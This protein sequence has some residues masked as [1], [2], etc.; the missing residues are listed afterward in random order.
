MKLIKPVS[1]REFTYVIVVIVVALV[2]ALLAGC[3]GGPSAIESQPPASSTEAGRSD[4]QAQSE[5]HAAT[6][7]ASGEVPM[8]TGNEDTTLIQPEDT[9]VGAAAGQGNEDAAGIPS[10]G[11]VEFFAHDRPLTRVY[12]PTSKITIK[13]YTAPRNPYAA[14][15]VGQCHWYVFGRIQEEDTG[16]PQSFRDG[17]EILTK[18]FYGTGGIR[19][20]D[21]AKQAEL[22]G[23][24]T[25]KEAK[26]KSIAVWSSERLSHVAFVEEMRDGKP[27][28]S[29]S[30]YV[31]AD[32]S[33]DVG[34]DVEV[35]ILGDDRDI[36]TLTLRKQPSTD[37][38]SEGT[39]SRF[40]LAKA[41]KSQ[42]GWYYLQSESV[43]GWAQQG[44]VGGISNLYRFTRIRRYPSPMWGTPDAYIYLDGI[45]DRVQLIAPSDRA[46]VSVTPTLSWNSAARAT[47]YWVQVRQGSTVVFENNNLTS[48]SVT[49]PSGK[50]ARN[51]TYTWRVKAVNGNTGSHGFWSDERSFTTIDVP[52][53]PVLSSPRNLERDVSLTP[54]LSWNPAARAT[55]YWVQVRQGS[56]VVFEN[57]NL[58][59]TSVT[60]SSGRLARNTTYTWRV[61][62]KNAVG[63]SNWSAEWSFTT[64]DVPAVPV[65]SSPRNLERDVSLT[66]TLSWNPAARATSYW[67]QVRQG[68]TV[69]FENNNLTS[70]SVTVP[71]G[72]LARNTTY[73]WR[74]KAK[75][76]VGESNW[77]A[78]WSFTTIDVP[79]VPVLSSP[80]N[81][82]RDVSLT[83]TLSW[84]PA[85]R[86]T[87]Y[88]VQVRQGSTV[89]FE[90]NNLTSTSVTVPSGR[91]A[92]NTTYTWRVKAKN[93]VG[94]SNWSA[95]W[96]FT[97]IDV[98]A[99]PVLSSPRHG[100]RDV[101]LTPTLSWNPAARATSY[102][103]QVRQGST[104]V[105][106]NNN[107]TSTSVTV[108]SGRL[109]RNT[110]Y[111]W[112]VKA[113]NAVGE[114]NW[115]AEWSFTTRR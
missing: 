86:A 115:S 36:E 2:S 93:A 72:R 27:C 49:V 46:E 84:N 114:S 24:A 73:T 71:S 83:P 44:A 6:S 22:Y 57:N 41:V 50:L 61:K 56:T 102:W 109:A 26:A 34:P 63:E 92:R 42:N 59:S 17:Y 100:E 48:T 111:T 103:V 38:P 106:E 94:E 90:N 95:E 64:I 40:A 31:R 25:G 98:P 8:G 15:F 82:E 30:N 104:V 52:A 69:V 66:P 10:E 4:A 74:V 75:N 76:A 101:S 33:F 79:A 80:R 51:T 65:L 77:S 12:D 112:R 70:T 60:V 85:A 13:Y 91:L 19:A 54:T 96:S 67:V 89:V 55:S 113:K 37:A 32:G 81:L 11:A 39:L 3:G 88:W 47:S 16:L 23:L 43:K 58:T 14:K 35:V 5:G 99:V 110:T 108:S 7:N 107:L 20:K 78:E 53:V 29:E 97:T 68:S 9:G 1:P 21:W 28:I 105:F 45:P 87:S 18:V 62:A